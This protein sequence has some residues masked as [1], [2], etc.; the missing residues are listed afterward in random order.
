[1]F[2]LGSMAYG[3]LG[4]QL[5]SK[6]MKIFLKFLLLVILPVTSWAQPRLASTGMQFIH[7]NSGAIL[8]FPGDKIV[9]Q[10]VLSGTK[11][12]DRDV[13]MLARFDGKLVSI[14]MRGERD[15]SDRAIYWT[16]LYAPL[17]ELSYQFV[18]YDSTAPIISQ[19]YTLTRACLPPL[20]VPQSHNENVDTDNNTREVL[21]DL[22]AKTFFLEKQVKTLN[23][24]LEILERLQTKLQNRPKS[25]DR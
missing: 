8:P 9:M 1:M 19:R 12:T 11:E 2:Y 14:P 22:I 21:W 24:S 17:G 13:R 5:I 10:T 23:T 7:S 18:L 20:D 3:K 25:E 6:L 16:N 15:A 4:Q